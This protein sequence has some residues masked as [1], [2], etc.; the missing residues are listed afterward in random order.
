[1]KAIPPVLTADVP[2]KSALAIWSLVLGILSPGCLLI[3]FAISIALGRLSLGVLV[4]TT[5]IPAMICGHMAR[6]RIRDS[7]G[8]MIGNGLAI[9]GLVMAYLTIAL[10]IAIPLFVL[11]SIPR[12]VK[13]R[14]AAM[15]N[16][17][18]N[19]LQIIQTAKLK[20]ASENKKED[21]D[22]PTKA[23]LLPYLPNQQFPRCPGRG[24]YSIK[25]V[26]QPP[27]CPIPSHKLRPDQPR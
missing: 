24:D 18:T 23:D 9:T 20:W 11:S 10:S 22:T 7:D 6:A 1:M 2:K 16:V 8:K 25:P 14:E 27:V 4:L 17:C 19:N 21:G 5:A 15:R 26:V 3:G 13:A 12:Q